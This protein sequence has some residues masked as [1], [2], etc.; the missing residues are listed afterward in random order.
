M[1]DPRDNKV[2]KTIKIGDQVWMAENLNYADST[3]TPSLLKRSWCYNKETENCAVAGRLYIW[4]AAIDS[5]ALYD[6]GNGV[7]CGD[8]KTCM[9]PAKVQGICPSGW[10]L[11]TNTEWQTLFDEVGGRLTAGKILKSQTGW[12][13]NGNG[14]DGGG[15][16]ALPAGFRYYDGTFRYAGDDANFWSATEHNSYYARAMILRYTGEG[17]GLDYGTKAY[18]GFSVRCLKDEP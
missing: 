4:A 9:L 11:P 18:D 6:G 12:Y 17:A 15:F 3:K 16:S 13:S 8:G 1:T 14:T 5:V 2:Y 10:H 7:D